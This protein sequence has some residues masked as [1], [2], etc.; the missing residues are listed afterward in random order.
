MSGKSIYERKYK[1]ENDKKN[2]KKKPPI[3]FEDVKN[4]YGKE[5]MSVAEWAV[6]LSESRKIENGKLTE[7]TIKNYI[8]T[9]CDKSNGLLDV[10]MF[11]HDA[12]EKGIKYE[13]KPQYHSLLLTLMATDCFDNR[14]NERRI[15]TR[16]ELYSQLLENINKYL[17]EK[18]KKN[19]KSNP[20][21]VN[22][23][24]ES[25]LTEKINIELT[26]LLRSMYHSDPVGRYQFMIETL[27]N[28]HSLRELIDKSESKV[29]SAKMVYAH[30]LDELEDAKYQKGLFKSNSLDEFIINYLAL[31]MAG[32]GYE[33]IYEDEELSLPA[34]Y[35]AVNMFN[36]SIK[37]DND[38][39]EKIKE[40]DS[41]I[42][43]EKRYIEIVKKAENILNI[44]DPIEAEI[45]QDLKERVAIR[46]LRPYVSSEEYERTIRFVES[47]IA[48]DK[49]DIINKL[50]EIGRSHMTNEQ[51]AEIMK[52]KD[53]NN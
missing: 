35:L 30:T 3:K 29:M 26:E 14:K 36:I 9:I 1:S 39:K 17:N 28:F 27:S 4:K 13:F 53:G 49:F 50:L 15:S 43:N 20:I 34:T 31:K 46:Y 22:S 38:I 44:K 6:Y 5:S 19:I 51:I 42:S 21:Y 52:I 8:K 7:K 23:V 33:Y 47:C 11:K 10:N 2:K 48:E 32:K 25:Y 45:Y 18:D 16:G 37:D 40:I 24:L 41:L 12:K